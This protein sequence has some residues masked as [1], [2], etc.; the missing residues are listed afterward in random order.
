MSFERFTDMARA[1]VF[2]AEVE[3]RNL[4]LS[5]VG[6][7]SLLLS[8]LNETRGVAYQALSTLGVTYKE[9][10]SQVRNLTEEQ[11][12]VPEEKLPFTP[13]AKIVLEHALREAM[14]LSASHIET[15]HL[16]LAIAR[17]GN[18]VAIQAL[19]QMGIDASM[20]R[21]AINELLHKP[22]ATHGGPYPTEDYY[23][24]ES[25][26]IL[27]DYGTNLT[28]QA[29][30]GRLDPVVGREREIERVMQIL[31]RRSKNNPLLIGDPG[32]GKTAIA[33]GLAQMIA[34]EQVPDILRHKQLITLDVAA[35][36]AGSKYRGEFEERMKRVVREVKDRDDVI[37]FI[38]EI[39]T[40]IGAGSAEGSID[41]AA[42][43]KPPL[44]RGEIQIIGAA[45]TEEY[46][47]HIEKDAALER[48]F[49][50]VTINEPDH[51]AAVRILERLRDRYEEHH[52]V[53]FTDEALEAAVTLADRYVQ[54]RYL[55]D[56]AIDVLD[57]AGA[58]MR[59][60]NMTIPTALQEIDSRIRQV[61][62]EKDT[63]IAEED[64][65]KAGSLRDQ[66]HKLVAERSTMEDEWRQDSSKN[67]AVVGVSEI[68]D[69]ISMSTGVPVA[70]LTEAE[71]EKLIRMEEAIHE[72]IIGQD[73]AVNAV[74]KAIRRSRAGLKDPKRP[75]GSFIFLGPSGV[76]KTELSKALAEFLFN[77]EEA[78]LSFDMSEYMEKH[79]VSR[80]VGS[81]PGYVGY[82]EGGQLTKAVRQRPY[83]V[84]LFDEIEKAH[85]DVFNILLQI[86]E[87]GRLTDGQGRKVDFRN[88]IIIMTSNVGA[89]EIAQSSPVGF[90]GGGSRGLSD[91]EINSRVM[92]EMKKLF[93][94]EFLNRIDE[95]IV[96]KTLTDEW[97]A[98]I[99][100]LLVSDLRDRLI[101]QNMSVELTDA[102]KRH[103]ADEGTD[104]A[105]GARPLRRAIQRLIEDPVSEQVLAGKFLPGTIIQVDYDGT[106]IVFAGVEGEIPKPRQR[107]S[108][109]QEAEIITSFF[110]G[111]SGGG[112]LETD[113][114]YTPDDS[115]PDRQDAL[116]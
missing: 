28:D 86:L 105:F 11:E 37:L 41:A 101:A 92:S 71:T 44:S 30:L 42:I 81:P 56:K 84:I 21:G 102:A 15:E 73:E 7:E 107:T 67:M 51:D 43:L 23:D 6:T 50:T 25:S 66:E 104:A 83:S 1:V 24:S 38:D 78:L 72:R 94:P 113:P 98:Q 26:G 112:G 69:I 36:V 10:L 46:R 106:A 61:R 22:Q 74:S 17:E 9:F 85:P 19:N 53:R 65:E 20:L 109:K 58:R 76:G 110:G 48:R 68:A 59:I 5:M 100:E 90:T 103:I 108:I 77:T 4:S 52:N 75:A 115:S 70:D 33:E 63:A 64:Y 39:H 99:V 18:G 8:L 32:V 40:I 114:S 80:L 27:Q 62:H 49:Q 111:R 16:L 79:T 82:D 29:K 89:R 14:K 57:E 31:S 55:P 97:I 12:D 47:K 3:A 54:D 95:I 60:R 96:F 45:T 91:E 35:L 34:Q 87:E 2:A 116:L 93:R 88:T 13:R